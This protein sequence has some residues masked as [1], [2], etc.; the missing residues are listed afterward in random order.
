LLRLETVFAREEKGVEGGVL[1][2]LIA[3]P[4][5]EEGLGLRLGGGDRTDGDD[6][7]QE[8]ESSSREEDD[9]WDPLVGER[10][11][12][13]PYRFGTGGCWAMG[14]IRD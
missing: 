8:E 14:S 11:R 4:G 2:L 1:G 7:V 5:L 12:G 10:G 9:K 13:V 6:P 3:D